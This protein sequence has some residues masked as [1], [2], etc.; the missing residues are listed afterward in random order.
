MLLLF[1]SP[2][3]DL[4]LFLAAFSPTELFGLHPPPPPC[5]CSF[6]KQKAKADAR[7]THWCSKIQGAKIATAVAIAGFQQVIN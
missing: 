6:Q 5:Y 7:E 1:Q 4:L 3:K 2:S